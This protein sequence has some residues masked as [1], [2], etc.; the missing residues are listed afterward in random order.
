MRHP[1][2][3]WLTR[4]GSGYDNIDVAACTEKG[5]KALITPGGN[6]TAVVELTLGLMLDAAKKNHVCKYR[7]KAK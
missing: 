4:A 5:I 6:V 2:C 1:N 3:K 7:L